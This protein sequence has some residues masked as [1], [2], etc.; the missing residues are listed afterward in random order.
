MKTTAW[1][2]RLIAA[3]LL[4]AG[5][6]LADEIG[7]RSFSTGF[8]A[9][10]G[11]AAGLDAPGQ[12]GDYPEQWFSWYGEDKA[13]VVTD[14]VHTGTQAVRFRYN[15]TDIQHLAQ[16]HGDP[17][18][19]DPNNI[20]IET[21]TPMVWEESFSF[22]VSS[23]RNQ[24][25]GYVLRAEPWLF[26][27]DGYYYAYQFFVWQPNDDTGYITGFE[28]SVPGQ[29]AGQFAWYGW[30]TA[31]PAVVTDTLAHTGN[32][33][34]YF[35]DAAVSDIQHHVTNGDPSLPPMTWQDQFSVYIPGSHP[36]GEVFR[37]E[38]WNNWPDTGWAYQFFLI[39]SGADPNDLD[40]D[41]W[42]PQ[43][44]AGAM[45]HDLREDFGLD[46]NTDAL[47]TDQ[48]WTITITADGANGRVIGVDIEDDFGTSYS[49]TLDDHF[50]SWGDDLTDDPNATWAFRPE[51]MY[52]ISVSGGVYA[53][54]IRFH[55]LGNP[56]RSGW[57]PEMGWAGN[58]LI[59][60]MGL[61]AGS[62]LA[63]DKWWNVKLVADG[64]AGLI[65]DVYISDDAGTTYA[66]TDLN[67]PFTIWG[68]ELD[69]NDIP[70]QVDMLGYG[71]SGDGVWIDD[72][73]FQIGGIQCSGDIDGDG[74]TDLSDLAELLAAYGTSVGDPNYNP[75]AD[76]DSDGTVD[77]ADL[78]VLLADYGCGT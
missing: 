51:R 21:L 31:P 47:A 9:V 68:S 30:Y 28:D 23:E 76:F 13:Q 12:P 3:G 52:Y 43:I 38:P 49:A 53:D 26:A 10:A 55:E 22:Y 17:N 54:D 69:P 4:T 2:T 64:G 61:P 32:H 37:S 35:P 14:R 19:Y 58:I 59:D 66:I 1:I 73:D 67:E 33:A 7:P 56:P 46:P 77:L 72:I 42:Y 18:G 25:S 16:Y 65:T 20:D 24:E 75:D 62:L 29:V 48:W 15:W 11:Y 6:V 57:W 8:E 41:G 78:A 34:V 63:A 27:S 70:P 74:D 36:N 60:E 40:P 44:G 39:R 5:A 45:A 71:S 50:S